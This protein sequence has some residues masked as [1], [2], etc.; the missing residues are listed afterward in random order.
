MGHILWYYALNSAASRNAPKFEYNIE[1][2]DSN[3]MYGNTE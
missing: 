1:A 3:H 2:W